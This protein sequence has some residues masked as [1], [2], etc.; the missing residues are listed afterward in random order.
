MENELHFCANCASMETFSH[1]ECVDQYNYE[2]YGM[3][4]ERCETVV[5]NLCEVCGCNP[6]FDITCVECQAKDFLE[7][8]GEMDSVIEW[9]AHETEQTPETKFFRTCVTLAQ[10]KMAVAS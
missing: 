4:C 3:Y 2:S 1:G 10:A 7:I 5:E 8:D 9:L 6:A